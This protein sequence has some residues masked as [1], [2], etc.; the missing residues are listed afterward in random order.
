VVSSAPPHSSSTQQSPF[1][2]GVCGIL[3]KVEELEAE[4]GQMGVVRYVTSGVSYTTPP[5]TAQS[6]FWVQHPRDPQR[7]ECSWDVRSSKSLHHLRQMIAQAVQSGEIKHAHCEARYLLDQV[8]ERLV[9]LVAHLNREGWSVGLICPDNVYFRDDGSEIFLADLGFY[10]K[11]GRGEPPWEAEPGRPEWV[12]PRWTYAW[13][14]SRPPVQQQFAHSSF[15]PQYWDGQPFTPPTP[16]EDLQC[17][18]RLIHWLLTGSTQTPQ[19][20]TP[21]MTLLLAAIEGHL[22]YI[23]DFLAQLEQCPPSSHFGRTAPAVSHTASKIGQWLAVLILLG[24]GIAVGTGVWLYYSRS[25]TAPTE[26]TDTASLPQ[27]PL[28]PSP[29][30]PQSM[31]SLPEP[32]QWQQDSVEKH[33]DFWKEYN[34]QRPDMQSEK[35]KLLQYREETL[36]KLIQKHD[37]LLERSFEHAERYAV[38]REFQKLYED[39]KLLRSKPIDDLELER[40]EK[41]WLEILELRVQ[42]LGAL[43]R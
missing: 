32:K 16:T 38:A 4:L 3:E 9:R 25:S 34:P 26:T 40:R 15:A 31:P 27:P 36:N 18:A 42:E 35:S 19:P 28:K 21:F 41:L 23:T 33:M 13:L 5:S 24:V 8:V 29:P 12:D 2:F 11:P 7:F 14:Y 17:L 37:Q 43:P 1:R 6:Y 10:W 22:A 20:T 30:P 39:L